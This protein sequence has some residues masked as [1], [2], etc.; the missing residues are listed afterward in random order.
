MVK[1]ELFFFYI[2]N[3]RKFCSAL[4]IFLKYSLQMKHD[5]GGWRVTAYL[6]HLV[7]RYH[8]PLSSLICVG[9]QTHIHI[10]YEKLFVLLNKH[11]FN[12]F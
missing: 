5:G 8:L 6:I 3:V 2:L 7:L 4:H 11:V 12:I 1:L 9:L 10:V